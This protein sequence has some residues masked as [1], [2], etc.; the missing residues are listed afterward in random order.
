MLFDI[1]FSFIVMYILRSTFL[2]LLIC[3]NGKKE[4]VVFDIIFH[5][6]VNT[7]RKIAVAEAS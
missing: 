1:I 4:A 5:P 3:L 2:W 6:I 7:V